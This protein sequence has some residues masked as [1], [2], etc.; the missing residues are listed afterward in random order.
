MVSNILYHLEKK[1]KEK[2]RKEKKRKEINYIINILSFYKILN[3]L[4]NF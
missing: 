2:K 4:F 3:S 1:K